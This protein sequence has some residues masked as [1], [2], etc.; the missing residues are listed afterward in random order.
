VKPVYRIWRRELRGYLRS[1]MGY[2]IL[3]A[4]LVIDG[5]LFN[6]LAVGSGGR[7][8]GDILEAFFF[9]L[10]GTTLAASVFISMRLI[11]EER[12]SGTLVLLFLTPLRDH[13]IIL[14]KYLAGL[15]FL[16]LLTA[17]TIYMP[18]LLLLDGKIALGHVF[19]GYL[20]IALIGAAALALGLFC[21]AIAPNQLVAASLSAATLTTFVLLWLLSRIASPPLDELV[22][23]LSIHDRHFRPFM[24]GVISVQDLAYYLTLTFVALVASTRV[25]ESRRWR[26]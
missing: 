10:S 3:A 19:A 9:Y 23:Y 25:L 6:A 11:A 26:E 4:T 16:L 8:S 1:P 18:A 13:Q 15:S 21:S 14:G 5:L 20:G 7:R 17:L 2:V 22:A 24:R 12:Q